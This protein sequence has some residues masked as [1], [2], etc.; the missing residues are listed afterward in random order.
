MKRGVLIVKLDGADV[1]LSFSCS[2]QEE[3][4]ELIFY[5]A[6]RIGQFFH[7]AAFNVIKART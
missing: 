6:C 3:M 4:S 2:I 7:L 1:D 5:A